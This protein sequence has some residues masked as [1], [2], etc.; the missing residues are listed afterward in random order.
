MRS[1]RRNSGGY[2]IIEVVIVLTVSALLFASSVTAYNQQ[3]RRTQFTSSVNNFA[4]GI[5]D[6]LN[7]VEDGFYPSTNS[8]SCSVSGTAAPS[9]NY[10]GNTEQGTNTNCV[11]I[12]KAIQF[13]PGGGTA[14]D[15]DVFTMVGRRLAAV[16]GDPVSDISQAKP[17]GL[18][19]LVERKSLVTG[20]NVTAVKQIGAGTTYSGIA[21]VANSGSSG[22]ISSGLGSRASIASVHG[23]LHDSR[24]SF[25]SHISSMGTANITDAQ[26]GINI[27]LAEAGTGGRTAVIELAA[28]SSQTIVNTRIDTPCP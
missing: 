7:D 19:N 16:T 18:N 26:N 15:I 25:L 24:P 1:Y 3:N 20:L 4:Q 21:M 17:V 13:V 8:F 23:G 10:S 6:V 22:G 9:I 11:F 5:Q 14:S 12:G 2:T 27:C 28:A